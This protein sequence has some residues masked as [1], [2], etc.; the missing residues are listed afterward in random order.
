LEEEEETAG[1]LERRSTSRRD[2]P[3]SNSWIGCGVEPDR[4]KIQERKGE[5]RMEIPSDRS[6]LG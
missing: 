3:T 2:R 1:W 5:V 6:V 4:G